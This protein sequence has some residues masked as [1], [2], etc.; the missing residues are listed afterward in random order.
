MWPYYAYAKRYLFEIPA[1]TKKVRILLK[2]S[3]Y[4][5]MGIRHTV[6]LV[7]AHGYAY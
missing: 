7:R 4:G 2:E 3:I 1:F 6:P 5:Y